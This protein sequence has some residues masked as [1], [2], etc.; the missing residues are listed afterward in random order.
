VGEESNREWS[1]GPTAAEA[2]VKEGGNEPINFV[3]VLVDPDA[4]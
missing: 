2:E 1:G 4:L 3:L